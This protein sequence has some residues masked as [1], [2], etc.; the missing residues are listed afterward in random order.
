MA[1]GRKS[2]SDVGTGQARGACAW[3]RLALTVMALVGA[4]GVAC[5]RSGPSGDAAERITSSGAADT[6]TVRLSG[7]V[8]AVQSRAV[9][10]PRLQG[11]AVPLLI[12]DL[13]RAGTRVEP[14]DLL[15]GFDPQQ[16]QRDA[17]DRHAEM[18]NLDGEI[19]KKRAEQAA[20]EAKDRTE[21]TAAENDV[22]RARLDVRKND[23][24]PR[25]E[26]EKNTLA[27]DRALARFEQ[28][29]KTFALK[30]EAAA[31]DLRILEIRRERA[32]RALRYAEANAKL[33]EVRAEFPGLV[34]IK[35]TY[36]TESLV[37]FAEGDEVR[38]G[39][40]ILEIVDTS[41]MRVRA[42]LNQAD[43][44]LVQAGQPATVGLDG[45]PDLQFTGEIESVTPLASSSRLSDTVRSFVAI[46][47]I[48]GS[49]P[50][51]LPDLTAWVDVAP[52]NGPV[53]GKG[54]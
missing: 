39:T 37:E 8:E 17:F 50:Q 7:T 38:P 44:R 40:A 31:A 29:G 16:Q 49:N 14:G 2:P 10:V 54:T 12:I 30:R 19:A 3:S 34:V 43:A 46:V 51:L 22:A 36:R 33:M 18:V 41:A 47:S 45:F 13:V 4:A 20:A 52:V 53:A 9:I 5:V 24:L 35:R 15:V 25:I 26:A 48:A 27:L 23:L 11:P 28:L 6:E 1:V 42:Q 32:E 21:L